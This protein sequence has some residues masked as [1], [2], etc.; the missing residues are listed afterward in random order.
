M[1]WKI[2][3]LLNSSSLYYTISM[4]SIYTAAVATDV[5][6]CSEMAGKVL[7]SNGTAVDAAITAM[8]CV[9]A[10]NPQVIWNRRV[11]K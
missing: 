7:E 2:W 10:V 8:L 3:N 9:G 6:V 1:I 11:R 5:P 4:I